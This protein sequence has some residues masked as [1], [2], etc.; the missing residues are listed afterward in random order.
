MAI[1]AV[2]AI[3]LDPAIRLILMRTDR[4]QFRRVARRSSK[5]SLSLESFTAK[6]TPDQ[7]AAHAAL[8]PVVRFVLNFKW[9]VIASAIAVV[10]LTVPVY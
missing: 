9:L 1:A 2:L 3:T 7:P 10:A 8:Y 6:R 5:C 4:F